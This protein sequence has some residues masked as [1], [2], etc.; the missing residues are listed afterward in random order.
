MPNIGVVVGD[1][2]ALVVDTG[3]GPENGKTV[4]AIAK[5]LA[6]SRPLT[7]T[8]T[9]F[10]PEHG[11]GAQVFK[12]VARILYNEAQRDELKRK[13]EGEHDVSARDMHLH[14]DG[15]GLDPLERH[16][17]YARHHVRPLWAGL[18]GNICRTFAGAQGESSSEATL[19]L[20][21]R[22]CRLERQDLPNC[23]VCDRDPQ[24]PLRA[25]QRTFPAGRRTG[26]SDP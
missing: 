7:L 8:L 16:G 25:K 26:Q 14:V 10:H 23:D 18:Y 19:Q 5:E 24:W 6:G 21:S 15:P 2:A 3:M 4:L 9:H 1:D 13:G 22:R 12:G 20:K 11:F 17:R